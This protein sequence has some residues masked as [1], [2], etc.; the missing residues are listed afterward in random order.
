MSVFEKITTIASNEQS[1]FKLVQV[2]L[3][4]DKT[5]CD[6]G[7]GCDYSKFLKLLKSFC[8]KH[9][10]QQKIF[11]DWSLPSRR[12]RFWAFNGFNVNFPWRRGDLFYVDKVLFEWFDR[13]VF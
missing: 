3:E 5:P 8:N 6:S 12:T 1:M 9:Y 13:I 11:F 4:V 2:L 7:S 10:N